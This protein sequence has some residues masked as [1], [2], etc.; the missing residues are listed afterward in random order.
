MQGEVQV[1]L[2]ACVIGGVVHLYHFF[3][4]L[5][6]QTYSGFILDRKPSSRS[7]FASFD[8]KGLYLSGGY[9]YMTDR[10]KQEIE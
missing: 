7:N 8:H 2:N 4:R 10:D 9:I 3:G 6:M 1:E 5:Q